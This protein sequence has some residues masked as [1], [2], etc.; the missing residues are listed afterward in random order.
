MDGIM[1]VNLKKGAINGINNGLSVLV[2]AETFDY[3]Y[4]YVNEVSRSGVGFKV[5]VVH[6]LDVPSIESVG[7]RVNVGMIWKINTFFI[8]VIE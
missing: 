1:L 8:I 2:D 3:G 6:H 7:T 4:Q 5:G